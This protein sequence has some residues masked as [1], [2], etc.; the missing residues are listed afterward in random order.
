[1]LLGYKLFTQYISNDNS[2]RLRYDI[3]LLFLSNFMCNSLISQNLIIL[4]IC[5]INVIKL[6]FF[7]VKF[8]TLNSK[9]FI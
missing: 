1:M 8:Q 4:F 5:Q 6:Y 3:F 2:V 7:L 9:N